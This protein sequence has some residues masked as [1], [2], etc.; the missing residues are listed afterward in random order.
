[1][2]VAA[3][4]DLYADFTSALDNFGHLVDRFIA[5]AR[6]CER[7]KYETAQY[8]QSLLRWDDDGGCSSG[9]PDDFDIYVPDLFHDA[10]AL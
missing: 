9:S 3:E 4:R 8:L 2:S 7:E 1:M 5:L 10:C 6:Q